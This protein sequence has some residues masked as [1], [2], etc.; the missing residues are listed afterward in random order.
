[1][2]YF[3]TSHKMAPQKAMSAVWTSK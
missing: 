2:S 1:M 3:L